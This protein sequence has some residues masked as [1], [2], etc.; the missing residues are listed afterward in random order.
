MADKEADSVV[1]LLPTDVGLLTVTLATLVGCSAAITFYST[2]K[3]RKIHQTT[4]VEHT[5]DATQDFFLSGRN[6]PWWA[7]G[8]SLFAAN[9]GSEHYIAQA[10]TA[11][12]YGFPVSLYE[13]MAAYL[14]VLLAYVFAPVYLR[15]AVVTV[16]EF[17]EKRYNKWCRLILASVCVL[18]Y[19]LTKIAATLFAS[20]VFL[21]ILL[22]WNIYKSIPVILGITAVYT[23]VG[24]L[25]AVIY[26]DILQV[27][28]GL[29]GGFAAL[30]VAMQ[31]VG[32]Y[33]G[34]VDAFSRTG[35]SDMLHVIRP[36]TDPNFAWTGMFFGQV[37][38]SIWVSAENSG[39]LRLS[40][41]ADSRMTCGWHVFR[42]LIMWLCTKKKY[43]CLDQEMAQRVLSARSLR[44]AR[45]GLVFAGFL[46]IMPP[47]VI[48]FVGLAARAM[49]ERCKLG[50]VGFENWCSVDLSDPDQA[51]KAYS[52][53]VVREFHSGLVGVLVAAMLAAMMGAL[54]AVLNSSASVLT[55]DIYQ[56]FINPVASERRLVLFGRL[57][58]AAVALLS[59]AWLPVIE[60]Q[61]N[62][63]YLIVQ[64]T[65]THF[66][67]P[68]TAI[69]V[70]GVFSSRINATGATAG[71]LV[72][73]IMGAVQ[74]VW[75]LVVK[76]ECEAFYDERWFSFPCMQ[77]NHYASILFVVSAITTLVG[78]WLSGWVP[79]GEERQAMRRLTVWHGKREWWG[80]QPCDTDV[81]FRETGPT[82]RQSGDVDPEKGLAASA[83]MAPP[84]S[85]RFTQAAFG[86]RSPASCGMAGCCSN[87]DAR[88]VTSV[89]SSLGFDRTNTRDI[90]PSEADSDHVYIP[91]AVCRL[92]TISGDRA[93]VGDLEALMARE[94]LL[95]RV[96]DALA[97]VLVVAVTALIIVWR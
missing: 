68:L 24:G 42:L 25:T 17:L 39:V 54:S 65:F 34:L 78:S 58:T 11:A 88:T 60:S 46:K 50:D 62:S 21:N 51:N 86:E 2:R 5:G 9:V 57:S 93:Y 72:G 59:V 76:R 27:V 6:M 18:S 35:H 44:H 63:L 38:S 53:L 79:E 73:L 23:A 10:G 55:F 30:I 26:T 48:L 52:L 89:V 70:M 80:S 64:D 69:F 36:V 61:E 87:D 82:P 22:G 77:F 85:F 83:Y 31:R 37:V 43:W 67:P 66:A 20:A 97:I 7:I 19:I 33:Q 32:G 12:L 8:A 71:L 96:N 45:S 81:I 56:R 16:P 90:A 1:H 41:P 74:Y 92:S 29:I 28:I 40:G 91:R 47:F 4:G 84:P 15:S 13:W 75:N 3:Q 95:S 94:R 49:F 14:L